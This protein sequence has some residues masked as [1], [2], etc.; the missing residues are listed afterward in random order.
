MNGQ[1]PTPSSTSSIMHS[2]SSPSSSVVFTHPQLQSLEIIPPSIIPLLS[3]P[4]MLSQIF[5]VNEPTIHTTEEAPASMTY[6]SYPFGT[7][8]CTESPSVAE[9]KMRALSVGCPTWSWSDS[10]T[11]PATVLNTDDLQGAFNYLSREQR[12]QSSLSS[13]CNAVIEGITSKACRYSPEEKRER[14]E[15]Y[16]SKRSQRNFNKKIQYACRKTLADTRPRIKGRFA[17]NEEQQVSSGS[18]NERSNQH[19]E[20]EEEFDNEE[21]WINLLESFSSSSLSPQ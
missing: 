20:R 11:S 19:F 12:A 8:F 9:R 13:D 3:E 5:D 1:S 18:Q 7:S 21:T 17:R 4:L 10:D 14:I 2:S 16:R 15:R 6:H